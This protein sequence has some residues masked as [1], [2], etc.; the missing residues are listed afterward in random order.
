[1]KH[2][3]VIG[4]DLSQA[5]DFLIERAFVGTDLVLDR[6]GTAVA[7]M[8][9][10]ASAGDTV[11][12]VILEN[13]K[14]ITRPQPYLDLLK[15]IRQAGL[16]IL[17][18][19]GEPL[20]PERRD[21]LSI[22]LR[23][24][25][26]PLYPQR[27]LREVKQFQWREETRYM[28]RHP[29][30]RAHGFRVGI[31]ADARIDPELV[32]RLSTW[33]SSAGNLVAEFNTLEAASTA[34]AEHEDVLIFHFI[35][36]IYDENLTPTEKVIQTLRANAYVPVLPPAAMRPSVVYPLLSSGAFAVLPATLP[37]DDLEDLYI[38]LRFA[39]RRGLST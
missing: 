17:L 1:M 29:G 14:P 30:R 26:P 33:F 28:V 13:R 16:P 20:A 37:S 36:D 24:L 38:S 34:F 9:K 7:A 4:V 8:H 10:L 39:P 12:V 11:L 23:V 6:A 5:G 3:P 31:L 15:A 22:W 35:T 2:V 25:E 19:C 27:L 32:R 21:T 18:L